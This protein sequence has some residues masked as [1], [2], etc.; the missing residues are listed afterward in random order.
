[1]VG[2]LIEHSNSRHMAAQARRTLG[3][4]VTVNRP[5]FVGGQLL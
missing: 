2:L 3:S 4:A 1:M 5:G